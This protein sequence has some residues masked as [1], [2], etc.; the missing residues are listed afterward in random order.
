MYTA[1]LNVNG[2]INRGMLNSYMPAMKYIEKKNSQILVCSV[3][4]NTTTCLPSAFPSSR[5]FSPSDA[6]SRSILELTGFI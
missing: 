4:Q 5:F 2:T 1:I 3:I 6:S